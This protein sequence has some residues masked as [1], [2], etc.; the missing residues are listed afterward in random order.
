L[1]P[2]SGIYTFTVRF[3][4]LQLPTGFMLFYLAIRYL[5]P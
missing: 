5:L 2:V 3:E 4:R 1:L